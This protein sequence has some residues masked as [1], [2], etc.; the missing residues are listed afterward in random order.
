MARPLA[1][2]GKEDIIGS[3]GVIKKVEFVRIITKALYSLGYERSG[4]ALEDES[5]IYLHS[6]VVNLF[7]QQVLDGYWDE[8][9]VTL[10]KID[11]LDE[12]ILKSASFLILEQKFFEL[13][14]KNRILDAVKT[15]RSEITPLDIKRKRVHELSGCIVS[16]SKLVIL[17]F[18]NVGT[19]TANSR[20]KL[21]EELQKIFPPTVMI[22]GRRL[23]LLVEQALSV[24]HDAC[25]FHNSLDS[26]LYTDHQCGKEQIPS[27]TTQVLQGHHDEVWFLQFSNNGKYLASS[28]SD[29]SVIIWEVLLVFDVESIFCS[30]QFHVRN[31]P[32]GIAT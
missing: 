15:L 32:F 13:L 2:E 23:E 4:A 5:G 26:S 28:S 6:S 10:R 8:S 17:G 21:L 16:S 24:Q 14:E 20:M 7:T 25:Y 30:L 29:R 31:M 27:Q 11:H 19:E 18:A 12:N 9:L 3:K 22:P 1:S